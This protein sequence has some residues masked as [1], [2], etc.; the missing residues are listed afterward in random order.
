MSVPGYW[1]NE[2]SGV[3][4]PIV[5]KYLRGEELEG[6]EVG[7]MRVYLSQWVHADGLVGPDVDALRRDVEKIASTDD[8]HRWLADALNAGIDPL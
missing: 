7:M 2:T 3:L 6:F 4:R 5:E 1:M 8:V